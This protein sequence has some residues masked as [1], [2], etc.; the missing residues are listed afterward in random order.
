MQLPPRIHR[1]GDCA[2]KG[3]EADEGVDTGGPGLGQ[4][5][6]PRG[7]QGGASRVFYIILGLDKGDV[8][9]LADTMVK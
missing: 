1:A 4:D 9:G 5:D 7:N 6:H 3:G 8:T 2:E